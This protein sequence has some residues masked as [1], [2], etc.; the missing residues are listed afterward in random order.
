MGFLTRI[1]FVPFIRESYEGYLEVILVICAECE[2]CCNADVLEFLGITKPSVTKALANLTRTDLVNIVNYDVGLTSEGRR[3]VE[4]MLAQASPLQ[5][6]A[7]QCWGDAQ[8]GRK[9]R[10]VWSTVSRKIFSV[11]WRIISGAYGNESHVIVA[12]SRDAEFCVLLSTGIISDGLHFGSV[13]LFPLDRCTW[14]WGVISCRPARINPESA[15]DSEEQGIV[16]ESTVS[17][18]FVYCYHSLI[19][20]WE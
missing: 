18:C 16:T 5:G 4:E 8:D 10:A 11:A 3:F 13:D 1:L 19:R 12:K 14:T 7:P 20:T 9:R 17:G 15:F 2:F 6:D